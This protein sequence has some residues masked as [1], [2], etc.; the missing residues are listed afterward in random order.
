MK[1]GDYV[2]VNRL[3]I[4]KKGCVYLV[5]IRLFYKRGGRKGQL[6]RMW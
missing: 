3:A 2:Q 6:Y 1:V 5:G 4:F